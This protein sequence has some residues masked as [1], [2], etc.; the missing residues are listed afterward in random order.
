MIIETHRL[1]S[2]HIAINI[3]HRHD[4]EIHLVQHLCH[5]WFFSIFCYNLKM[6]HGTLSHNT[7]IPLSRTATKYIFDIFSSLFTAASKIHRFKDSIFLWCPMIFM[8]SSIESTLLYVFFF[9]PAWENWNVTNNITF[10]ANSPQWPP[11]VLLV[12]LMIILR[13]HQTFWVFCFVIY[14]Y[15][16]WSNMRRL[17]EKGVYFNLTETLTSLWA[18]DNFN[19][20]YWM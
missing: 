8:S 12:L 14:N 5:A 4:N 17:L 9:I 16:K 7:Q 2:V 6:N 19:M 11:K 3:Q 1:P 15:R 20:R 13:Y 18:W 10:S